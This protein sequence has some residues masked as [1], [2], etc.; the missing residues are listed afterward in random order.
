MG[1]LMK[2]DFDHLLLSETPDPVI[3]TTP[4]GRVVHWNKG[5]ET[6]FGYTSAE[7]V[8]REVNEIIVPPDRFDEERTILRQT[9]TPNRTRSRP[10]ATPTWSNRSIHGPCPDWW[11]KSWN[12]I[13]NRS[14]Q[15]NEK[16]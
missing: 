14:N 5:A 9:D 13:V 16:S 8:G 11:A 1:K 2:T 6:V 12:I 10:V 7:A 4:D 3:I 15:P